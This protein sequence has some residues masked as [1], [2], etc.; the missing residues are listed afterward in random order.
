[1]LKFDEEQA[2]KCHYK[3]TRERG[4]LPPCLFSGRL[5]AGKKGAIN[6]TCLIIAAG[7]GSRLANRGDCKPLVQ[8]GGIP[9]IERVILTIMQ[10]GVMD[11]YVITGCNG[12]KIR[13][14]LTSFTQKHAVTID[15]IHNDQWEKPNGISVHCAQG[16]IDKPF[17]LLMSDHMFD[18]QIVKELREEGVEEGEIKLAVDKRI[19]NNPLV[20]LDDVTKVLVENGRI[21]DIGKTI[22]RYNAFDTGIFLCTPA[23]FPALEESFTDGDFSLSGGIRKLAEKQKARV[24]DIGNRSWIDIDDEAAF[25]KAQKL[26]AC[27]AF[28]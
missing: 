20:D 25:I 4:G 1:M 6:M 18:P 21:L 16:K 17:L 28:N 3:Y 23:L 26:F 13:E 10:V 8:L 24:F 15:F 27:D 14:R 7:K 2:E 19:K 12:D 9:L 22:P 5:L 11:F